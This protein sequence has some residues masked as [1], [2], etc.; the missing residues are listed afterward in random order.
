MYNTKDV[1]TQSN[2]LIRS[3][4][5]VLTALSIKDQSG[6]RFPVVLFYHAREI[7][8]QISLVINSVKPRT[9]CSALQTLKLS[10]LT[11]GYLQST[12]LIRQI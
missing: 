1:K 3:D 2:P 5:A 10:V 7:S 11:K 12:T 8:N 4:Y 9:A 6:H